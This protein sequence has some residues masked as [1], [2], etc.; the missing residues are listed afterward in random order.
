MELFNTV[1]TCKK[2]GA[3]KNTF[4]LRYMIGKWNEPTQNGMDTGTLDLRSYDD[5]ILRE[6]SQ[7]GFKW[8]EMPLDGK[9]K[10]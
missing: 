4:R 2:C 1:E 8:A 9:G 10:K 5:Y 7:C 3:D 6:C